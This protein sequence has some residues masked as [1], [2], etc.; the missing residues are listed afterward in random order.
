MWGLN[1]NPPHTHTTSEKWLPLGNNLLHS[2]IHVWRIPHKTKKRTLYEK[3]QGILIMVVYLNL[4]SVVLSILKFLSYIPD[5][6][7]QT[8]RNT[9]VLPVS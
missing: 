7:R 9:R 3:S 2:Q 8:S 4:I 1:F 5:R 6:H